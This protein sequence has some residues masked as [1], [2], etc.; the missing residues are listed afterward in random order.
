MQ[1][2]SSRAKK[3][4]GLVLVALQRISAVYGNDGPDAICYFTIKS[5]AS[6]YNDLL[7]STLI[8]NHSY[9]LPLSQSPKA[10]QPSPNTGPILPTPLPP[11]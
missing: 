8:Q 2:E 6:A 5:S 11:Y 9:N 4:S 1:D 3:P 7:L 10:M